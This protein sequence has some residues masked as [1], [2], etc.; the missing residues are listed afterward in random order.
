M[1][2]RKDFTIKFVAHVL[3]KKGLRRMLE[4]IT[5]YEE[6]VAVTG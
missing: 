4:G 2:K 5:T 1:V 3:L 6:V